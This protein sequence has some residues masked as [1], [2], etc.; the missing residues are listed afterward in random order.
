MVH[1][2]RVITHKLRTITLDTKVYGHIEC[3]DKDADFI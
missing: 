3:A 1:T 2:A